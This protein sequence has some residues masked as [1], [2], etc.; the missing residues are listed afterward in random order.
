MK[1]RHYPEPYY[2]ADRANARLLICPLLADIH[3]DSRVAVYDHNAGRYSFLKI[4][5]SGGRMHI[6]LLELLPLSNFSI[7]LQLREADAWVDHLP[8]ARM[9]SLGNFSHSRI[10]PSSWGISGDCV[11][12]LRN[13]HTGTVVARHLVSG[14]EEVDFVYET[15]EGRKLQLDFFRG[16]VDGGAG[17][18]LLPPIRLVPTDQLGRPPEHIQHVGPQLAY[19][20]RQNVTLAPVA[21]KSAGKGGVATYGYLGAREGMEPIVEAMDFVLGRQRYLY[22]PYRAASRE[23]PGTVIYLGLPHASWGHFLTQGLARVWYALLHPEL[24]VVWD[25]TRLQPY[26]QE[27]LDLIGMENRQHFLTEPVLFENVI[28]PFPGVCLGDFVLKGFTDSIGRVPRAEPVRGKKIFLSRSGLGHAR[29]GLEGQMDAELDRLAERYGF[30]LFHPERHSIRQQLDEMSSSEVVL[31]V[32][33]S[34]LHSVLLLRGPLDT[35]LWALSRHRGGS[36]V[37]A[38]IKTAKELKYETLNFLR[39]PMGGA[40]GQI[41]IDL[42]EFEAA[43]ARTEGLTENLHLLG[44]RIERPIDAQ[45]SFQAHINNT[46][47]GLDRLEGDLTE[48]YF[49]LRKR[50][51]TSASAIISSYL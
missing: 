10:S 48:A 45:T 51:Y 27:V 19:T 47:T 43:L 28:F 22:Q 2:L 17:A 11:V 32:E 35:R 9:G 25:S 26:Q 34:A 13:P 29:G 20:Q 16:E 5:P 1:D 46:Q 4:I 30:T 41:D 23:E 7:K 38:H 14:N 42:G 12:I 40:R 3:G 39:S 21:L 37:F 24:P 31:A 49:A 50:D 33:G 15:A 18:R 6:P 8:P 36:G 44:N